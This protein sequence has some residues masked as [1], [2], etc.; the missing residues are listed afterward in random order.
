MIA[1]ASI[2][3]LYLVIALV[4]LAMALLLASL[5]ALAVTGVPVVGSPPAAL[6]AAL[7]LLELKPGDR[8]LE[9]GCGFGRG[10]AAARRR[11]VSVTA[12]E[13]NLPVWLVAWCRFLF[14]AQVRVRFGDA[15]RSDLR[16]ANAVFAYL[17]PA[18]LNRFG[19]IF[20]QQLAPGTRIA[21]MAFPIPGWTP[22]A[23]RVAAAADVYL[24]VV[25]DP[26]AANA[27]PGGAP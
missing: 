9:L 14:D 6:Q 23:S 27:S 20:T 3:V 19:P 16:G 11:G 1:A 12:W 22:R 10:V 13:L 4:L 24:F 25:G 2:S 26:P 21:T 15:R 7:D 5:W 17:M 8:L 18:A